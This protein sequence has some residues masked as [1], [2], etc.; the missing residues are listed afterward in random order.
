VLLSS[1]CEIECSYFFGVW[2]L[3]IYQ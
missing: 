3:V 2:S 1:Y